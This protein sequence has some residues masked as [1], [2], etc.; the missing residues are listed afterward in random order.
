[1]P[2]YFIHQHLL[3]ANVRTVIKDE[4]G[5]SVYLLVGRWGTKGDVLSIYQLD[6][7][8]LASVKQVTSAMPSH[9]DLY[10]G[11]EKVGTLSRLFSVDR[12][13]YLIKKLRWL[14]VGDIKNQDYRIYQLNQ[15][16]MT[17]KKETTYKGDFYQINVSDE[18]IA[19]LCIC[20]AAILDYWARMKK[21]E[22]QVLGKKWTAP[23]MYYPFEKYRKKEDETS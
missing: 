3:S 23:Q 16:L 7:T 22:W 8:I 20:V 13:F 19:P 4:T 12:D 15:R 18:E 1:M 10:N 11:Y 9:F 14:A 17:M 6:G 5:H 21:K 2:T